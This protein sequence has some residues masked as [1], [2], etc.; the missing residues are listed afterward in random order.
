MLHNL[1]LNYHPHDVGQTD[2]KGEQAIPSLI[3]KDVVA[4]AAVAMV[5]AVVVVVLMVAV[6]V[7]PAGAAAASREP[8]QLCPSP[9]LG[10]PGKVASQGSRS[11]PSPPRAPP[12]L[13]LILTEPTS[14]PA[15]Q[16]GGRSNSWWGV[17]A[18]TPPWIQPGQGSVGTRARPSWLGENWGWHLGPIPGPLV[19]AARQSP[20]KLGGGDP[21]GPLTQAPVTSLPPAHLGAQLVGF[22][23]IA[24]T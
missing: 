13:V 16:G 4:A 9:I 22:K 17:D 3:M 23:P 24:R 15:V 21:G 1:P 7:V 20:G 2:C 10:Y 18:R 8:H 6:A 14:G 19:C 12:I 11:D 5:P